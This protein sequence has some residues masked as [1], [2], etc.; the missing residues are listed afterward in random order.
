MSERKEHVL[1]AES[2]ERN[3]IQVSE[4]CPSNTNDGTFLILEQTLSSS[5]FSY[6][7]PHFYLLA[8]CILV[9]CL[10]LSTHIN[11]V[12]HALFWMSSYMKLHG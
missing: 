8:H 2:C 1:G 11:S 7:H 12:Q 10:L 3:L 9:F 5:F 4:I 6:L